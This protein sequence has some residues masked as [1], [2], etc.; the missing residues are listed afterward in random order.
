MRCPEK[1][2]SLINTFNGFVSVGFHRVQGGLDS[3]LEMQGGAFVLSPAQDHKSGSLSSH[4]S[5]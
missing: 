5:G 1:S 3:T 2:S 4:G